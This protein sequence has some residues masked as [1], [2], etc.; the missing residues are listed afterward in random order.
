MAVL[1]ATAS[2]YL[3]TPK[4]PHIGNTTVMASY[5]W[6]ATSATVGDI[7]Y[8]AKIPQ[9]AR[10]VEVIEDHSTGATASVVRNGLARGWTTG[11]GAS[12]SQVI[13]NGAQATVNRR[14]VLGLPPI[15]SVSDS[16]PNRFGDLVAKV[17]SGTTTT[18]LFL[19]VVVIYTV[20]GNT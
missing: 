12:H 13:A 11:G 3:S 14:N 10:I 4:A 6:G 16:D 5:A 2:T 20:D 1:S 17:E 19:N 7:I 15:I 8:L 18:S 9:G